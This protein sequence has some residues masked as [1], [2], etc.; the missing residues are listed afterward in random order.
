MK[1]LLFLFALILLSV[2]FIISCDDANANLEVPPS[3]NA[4]KE[5]IVILDF[6]DSEAA[7]SRG[8]VA[9]PTEGNP[10]FF[11]FVWKKEDLLNGLQGTS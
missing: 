2:T 11:F 9:F 10:F 1:K 7:S 4:E 5:E 8:L 3:G 6:L